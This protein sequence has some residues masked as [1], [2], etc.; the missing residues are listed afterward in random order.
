MKEKLFISVRDDGVATRLLSI[1]NALYLADKFGTM[2][3][4]K[5]FWNSNLV[6]F[7]KYYINNDKR[8][9]ENC[10]II[11]QSVGPVNLIFSDS[12]IKKH[13]MDNVNN[14]TTNVPYL[15]N[16]NYPEDVL[17]LLTLGFDKP[18][19]F[20]LKE[21]VDKKHIYI[22]QHNLS[23]QFKGIDTDLQ[24][25]N[26]LR[27]LWR[28]I[29]FRDNLKQYMQDAYNKSKKLGDF[30]IVHVRSGDV[31]Y[32]YSNARKFN[33]EGIYHATA[34]E[35]AMG[36][37]K[38][39]KDSK[40]VIVGDDITSTHILKEQ[41]NCNNIFHISEFRS[42]NLSNLELLL[43]D[44]IF[45]SNSKKIFGTHSALVTLSSIIG[46]EKNMVNNYHIFNKEQQY[47]IFK[48]YHKCFNDT[49]NSQ[50]A[51]SLFHMYLLGR[52]L[53]D[54]YAILRGY[55]KKALILDPDND[56]YRIHLLD[57]LF[58]YNKLDLIEKYLGIILKKRRLKWMETF[59]SVSWS[60]Y[61]YRDLF[62]RY[63]EVFQSKKYIN[64]NNVASEIVKLKMFGAHLVRQ[65]LSFKLGNC[66]LQSRRP[67][68]ILK[69]PISCI[70]I[71]IEYRCIKDEIKEVKL[72][73]CEDYAEVLKIKK[74]LSYKLGELIVRSFKNWY[75][76][77]LLLLPFKIYKLKKQYKK[78]K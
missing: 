36:I 78:N 5:F 10:N 11:G 77:D 73:E 26:K 27:E 38:E 21:I 56:K 6:L 14:Y 65:H 37:I 30:T 51:F 54:E 60:G 23:S 19:A 8:I 33:L 3:S 4:M 49:H 52:C 20:F 17:D 46:L 50:K 53:D 31:I 70:Q 61:V 67:F 68:Q 39:Q 62:Y 2:E 63:L 44:L 48:K 34:L 71:F 29:D 18:Y 69:L 47:A 55:L 59:F 9:F 22:H 66:I 58:K 41:A 24:Y 74:Y 13:Y 64:I 57:L 43:F 72:K 7:N 12:F 40:V 15:K 45:M 42:E 32:S 16:Y 25:K 35:I 1:L 76:G 75:K 28:Y